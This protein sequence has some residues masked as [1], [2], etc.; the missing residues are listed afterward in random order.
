MSESLVL[1]LADPSDAPAVAALHADSWRRHYRGAYADAFLDGDVVSDRL[2]VWADRLGAG[3]DPNGQHTLLAEANGELVGFAHT[4]FGKDPTWGALLDNLH[5]SHR[6]QRRGLGA[7]LL[8][9]SGAAVADSVP[10]SGLYLWV[11]EQNTR[12]QAFYQALGGT[13]VERGEVPPPG[14]V[15]GRLNGAPACLRYVWP[16]PESLRPMSPHRAG[17]STPL[18]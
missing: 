12:A 17:T 6:Y 7:Q 9:R 14:G 15:P 13:S 18:G 11:L 2:A 16:E 8:R 10:G 5:V 4:I 3:G 1:R